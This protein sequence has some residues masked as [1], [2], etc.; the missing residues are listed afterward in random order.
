MQCADVE[1][2][3]SCL[4]F[5]FDNRLS[6]QLSNLGYRLARVR[7]FYIFICFLFYCNRI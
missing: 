1:E 3:K 4:A 7:Q 2:S 5:D 6:E